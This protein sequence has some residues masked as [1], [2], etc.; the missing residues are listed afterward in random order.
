LYQ[1]TKQ[2]FDHH[3]MWIGSADATYE[4][5]KSKILPK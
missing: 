3:D 4:I 2:V 1:R 5:I